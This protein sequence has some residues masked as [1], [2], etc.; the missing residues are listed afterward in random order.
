MLDYGSLIYSLAPPS[1]PHPECFRIC[2]GAFHTSP[3]LSL[4]AESGYL[5]LHY[6]RLNLTASLLTSILQ[7]PNTL[8]HDICSLNRKSFTHIRYFLNHTLKKCPLLLP[9]SHN[10]R[11]PTMGHD[12]FQLRRQ[13]MQ[14]SQEFHNCHCVPLPLRR[15]PKLFPG[16]N[17]T[18]EFR[19][20]FQCAWR[21]SSLPLFRSLTHSSLPPTPYAPYPFQMFNLPT[22]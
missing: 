10:P 16:C 17:P 12:P 3:T 8:V 9:T 14:I 11:S 6:R 13:T 18:V 22:P 19:A 5:P 7:L 20:T 4:C 2:T 15:N 21:K 1:H